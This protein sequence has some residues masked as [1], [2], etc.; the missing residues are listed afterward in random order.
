MRI[1][2]RDKVRVP[3]LELARK[4][5]KYLDADTIPEGFEVLDPS[6]LTKTMIGQLWSHWSARAR[7]ELPILIF[8]KARKQDLGLSAEWEVPR[9][10]GKRIAYV[11]VG[12]DDQP[13]EDE[14]DGRA[15]KGKDG[16]DKDQGMSGSPVG[17]P[18][19]KRPRFS[20]QP[21]VPEDQSPAANEG[22]RLKFLYSLSIDPSY[23]ALLNG[24]LAL[25]DFVRL[26][27]L[28]CY[29]FV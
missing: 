21:A 10:I 11:E 17:P 2:K 13:S 7:K 3:W 25:P 5:T 28:Y 20:R 4:P 12:S 18:P 16:A 23:N 1:T 26:F 29:G 24:I 19:P 22:E 15:G 8:I 14:L 6:K 27:F 9:F